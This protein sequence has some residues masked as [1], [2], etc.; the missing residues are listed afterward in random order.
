[1]KGHMGFFLS[2]R[3]LL[4]VYFNAINLAFRIKVPDI[5][6]SEINDYQSIESGF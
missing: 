4:E 5:R 6:H 1:M 3:G 2:F